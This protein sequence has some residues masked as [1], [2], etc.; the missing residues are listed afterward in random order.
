MTHNSAKNCQNTDLTLR[1]NKNTLTN[2]L[3]ISDLADHGVGVNLA[4]VVAPILLLHLTHVQQP[5]HGVVVR[6]AEPCQS[7]DHVPVDRKDHLPVDMD[8]C[9]L[10]TKTVKLQ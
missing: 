5:G 10:R 7:R 8:P 3:Q 1:S 6:D 4:H 9:H 2:N